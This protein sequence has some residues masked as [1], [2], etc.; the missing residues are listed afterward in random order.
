[1]IQYESVE[2][3]L[4]GLKKPTQVHETVETIGITPGITGKPGILLGRIAENKTPVGLG[5]TSDTVNNTGGVFKNMGMV[6]IDLYTLINGGN[7][8]IA[9][10][11]KN[12]LFLFLFF[13]VRFF[14]SLADLF[15]LFIAVLPQLPY[16]II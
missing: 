6:T 16:F 2:M 3:V 7:D 9:A 8:K 15:Q 12:V 5:K 13:A 10:P 11:A 14:Y 4:P 1:M